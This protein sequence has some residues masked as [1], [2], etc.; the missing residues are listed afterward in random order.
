M[1][2]CLIGHTGFVG[3][4]LD[5]QASFDARYNS[6][7]IHDIRDKQFDE[8]YCA[9]VSAVKWYANQHPEEDW[10]RIQLLLDQL[11]TVSTRR[12][13]I[14]ST[15]DVYDPPVRVN[16][17]TPILL[18]ALKPYGNHRRRVELFVEAHFPDH[19]I[20]RLPGLFGKGL[21]KNVIFDLLHNNQMENIHAEAVFQFYNLANIY[22]DIE[23]AL[24]H[25]IRLINFAT[26]PI[27]VREMAAY[28]FDLNFT[29]IPH[30]APP[31]Y[32]MQTRYGSVYG[33]K[34]SPYILSKKEVLDQIRFFV[35]EC[36]RSSA[37]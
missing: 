24:K 19:C 32:D 17:D 5:A 27:S 31:R 1:S 14:I 29:N 3:G 28:A 9:G 4:N 35:R 23:I 8:V 37:P 6:A 34:G 20:V 36:T 16:E 12:F 33:H 13:I 18:S 30:A 11:R 7:N 15:V 22:R 10:Q 26:E 21:K 25:N 2:K